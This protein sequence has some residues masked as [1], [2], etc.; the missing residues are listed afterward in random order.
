MR[1][2]IFAVAVA[3][4][5]AA[6][7]TRAFAKAECNPQDRDPNTCAAIW[8]AIGLPDGGAAS[9]KTRVCHDRFVLSHDNASKTPDWV[10]E[11]LTKA[12]L[13]NKFKR[14]KNISF[15][16]DLCVPAAGQP[17]P[18]DYSKTPEKFEIG[19]MAPSDDFNNSDVNMRDTFVFSN[20]VPQAGDTFNAA[21]WRSLESEV[22]N[23]AIARK[24][25]YV[26]TGPIRGDG[27]A[28]KID[29]AKAD[30][31]CGGAIELETF[32]TRFVCKARNKGQTDTCTSGVVVP[33]ALYKIIYDPQAKAAYAFVMGN[34]NYPPK[35]GRSFMEQSRV[36]VGVIEKLT[37]LKFFT[38][39]PAADRARLV[40]KCEQTQMWAAATPKKTVKKSVKKTVKKNKKKKKKPA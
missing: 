19:H 2:I 32:P 40:D 35:L 5:A 18:G 14:P 26:V 10:I 17:D 34:H 13:T 4:L 23:A 29:I 8:R 24:T 15:S 27:T 9:G 25:I 7:S 16:G 6:G 38:A 30:N 39:L 37:G 28:R 11:N 20:A 12:K 33:I 36:N 31:A 22:R 3:G 1:N 21:I